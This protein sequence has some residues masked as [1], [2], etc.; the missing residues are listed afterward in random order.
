MTVVVSVMAIF[1]TLLIPL[2]QK[3]LQQGYEV[4]CINNLKQ[5]GQTTQLYTDDNNGHFPEFYYTKNEHKKKDGFVLLIQPP[6]A[7]RDG[8]DLY[9][10]EMITCE[11]DESGRTANVL[12][13]N[14]NIEAVPL[15]YGVNIWL[16]VY[17]I[18]HNEL[19]EPT[20]EEVFFDGFMLSKD[21]IQGKFQGRYWGVDE[22]NDLTSEYRHPMG[23]G[24]LNILYADWHVAHIY[25]E[26]KT[27]SKE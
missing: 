11:T 10:R 16:D 4:D 17:N 8:W 25:K 5:M 14:G 27:Y 7:A 26:D 19:E 24:L 12:L 22:F 20:Q 21:S 18:K 23:T 3:M 9:N 6:K 2:F 15:S 13:K 1:T